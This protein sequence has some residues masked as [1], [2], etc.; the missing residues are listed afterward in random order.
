[1]IPRSLDFALV[2][3]CSSI[4]LVILSGPGDFLSLKVFRASSNSFVL[5]WEFSIQVDLDQFGGGEVGG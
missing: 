1:M 4:P 3:R 2:P 5:N